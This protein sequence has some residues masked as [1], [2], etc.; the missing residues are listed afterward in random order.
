MQGRC[1]IQRRKKCGAVREARRE[2]GRGS[3]PG[4]GAPPS[5]W[6]QWQP[7]G[8]PEQ[9]LGRTQPVLGLIVHYG[10]HVDITLGGDRD[11]VEGEDY[12]GLFKVRRVGLDRSKEKL[13]L[14]STF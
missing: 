5:F 6:K 13:L 12:K 8:T 3:E 10:A 2:E 7:A 11:E 1:R 4:L 9:R 14:R